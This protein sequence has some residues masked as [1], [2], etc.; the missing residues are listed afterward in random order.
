MKACKKNIILV[1]VIM[2][3][4]PAAG[5]AAQTDYAQFYKTDHY[6]LYAMEGAENGLPSLGKELEL[7]FEVFNQL[8]RFGALAAP[9]RV[10]VFIDSAAYDDYVKARLGT[11]RPGAVYLHYN[12]SERR[13][14]VVL[15]GSP[16]EASMVAYQSFIQFLRGYIR[17]PPSWMREGFAIYFN[18]IKFDPVTETLKY[19]ENLTWLET[20]KGLGDKILHPKDIMLR[21]TIVYNES[22]ASSTTAG[23]FSQDFQICSWA[24]VS[25]L[26]NSGDY[27]RTLTES[28]MVL[29]P[30]AA[31]GE[32]S[33][34]VLDR[35]SMWT[36]MDQL[37]RDFFAYLD[38]RRTFNELMDAGRYYYDA[39]N[40]MN[41]EM[42]FMSAIDLRPANYAPYYYLG[43]IYYEDQEFDMAEDFYKLSME[44]GADEAL[45]NYALGI[46]AASAGRNSDAITWLQN[47]ADLNPD[48]FK[49]RADDL[50]S[51]LQ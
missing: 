29:S 23:F 31:A 30:I 25:F 40:L 8:F 1:F 10:R 13:E 32:N 9:L 37:D 36:D 4:I 46:N 41:A 39:K 50:I 7:R 5:L 14:L 15:R 42:A 19:E 3:I 47:A 28:F 12:Q 24:L 27:F 26:L 2:A 48:R 33:T 21:D 43:L 20:L 45:V 17:N 34:A 38:S 11:T 35:F 6:E 16:E 49:E 22:S 44:Y 18:S 51:K